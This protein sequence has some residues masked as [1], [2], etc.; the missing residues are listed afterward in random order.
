MATRSAVG[1]SSLLAPGLVL[2]LFGVRGHLR[3]ELKYVLRL[4]GIRDVLLAYQLYQAQRHEA[5]TDELEETLRQG[6]FID[7]VDVASGLVAASRGGI[8][9][10]TAVMAIGTALAAAGLG[11]LGRERTG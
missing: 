1:W 5:P 3:G 4:F 9:A 8:R 11:V 2:R 7:T 10:R 6:I